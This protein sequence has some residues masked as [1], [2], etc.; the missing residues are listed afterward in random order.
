MNCGD[1]IQAII[2]V[3]AG[4][5]AGWTITDDGDACCDDLLLFDEEDDDEDEL[6]D[7]GDEEGD[8]ES[9]TTLTSSSFVCCCEL[10]ITPTSSSSSSISLFGL[11][12]SSSFVDNNSSFWSRDGCFSTVLLMSWLFWAISDSVGLLSDESSAYLF[13]IVVILVLLRILWSNGVLNL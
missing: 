6:G 1:E 8:D 5:G 12:F 3:W 7:D 11:S 10:V 9:T 13:R 2:W 4:D